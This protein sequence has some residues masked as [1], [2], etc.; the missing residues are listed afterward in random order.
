MRVFD[1]FHVTGNE[2]IPEKWMRRY[3]LRDNKYNENWEKCPITF[4]NK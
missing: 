4:K 3:N 1:E 2:R